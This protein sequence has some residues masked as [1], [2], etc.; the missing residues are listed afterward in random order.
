ME[1]ESV[2][3]TP[4]ALPTPN[5][6]P[7]GFSPSPPIIVG[8]LAIAMFIISMA[9]VFG[10][11]RIQ[12]ESG[13]RAHG[14]RREEEIPKLWDLW[15]NQ[16]MG[17]M[18]SDLRWDNIKVRALSSPFTHARIHTALQPIAATTIPE[19][20]H[21]PP[22]SIGIPPIQP[23]S[24]AARPRR[25]VSDDSDVQ[26]NSNSAVSLQVAIAIAMPSQHR[27]TPVGYVRDCQGG[28]VDLDDRF[29]YTIG[30]Y[31]C[32]WIREKG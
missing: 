30:L 16:K 19:G 11:K 9:V 24:Q 3:P 32:P 12:I 27:Q 28:P 15:S 29:D 18:E 22:A 6:V 8:F 26:M 2:R 13:I 23:S 1:S 20:E 17:G 10:W 14:V 7:Q 4:S 31:R 21:D 25:A 5:S